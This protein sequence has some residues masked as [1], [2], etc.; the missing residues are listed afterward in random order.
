MIFK[1]W[2]LKLNIF[3]DFKMKNKNKLISNKLEIPKPK[4]FKLYKSFTFWFIIVTI[5]L[6]F[7]GGIMH[8][9][10]HLAIMKGYGIDGE[11]ELFSHFPDF[12]TIF[13]E[14]CPSEMCT[15]SHNFNEIVSYNLD[16]V[17]WEIFLGFAF[18]IGMFEFYMY[19]KENF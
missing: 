3:W 17:F 4:T 6:S 8:E 18:L 11:M 9:Q 7:Y 14:G 16:N 10:T 13:D 1:I 2:S 19:K 12:V 15:L 5:L